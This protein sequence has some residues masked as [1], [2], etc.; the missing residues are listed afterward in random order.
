MKL[1]RFDPLPDIL[2]TAVGYFKFA[3]LLCR[4]P[5]LVPRFW[6]LNISGEPRRDILTLQVKVL[7]PG[8]VG[9]CF[10]V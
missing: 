5:S 3:E 7:K 9:P 6:D 4:G 2:V 10:E 1:T 8:N